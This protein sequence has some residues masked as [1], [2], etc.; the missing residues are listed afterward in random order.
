MSNSATET[1]QFCWNELMTK[2]TEKA[3]SFYQALLGWEA[4]EMKVGELVYTVFKAGGKEMG[5]MLQIPAAEEQNIPPHWM[6]YIA[7]ADLDQAVKKAEQLGARVK[8]PQT[9]LGNFGRFATIIDPSG[10]H[11][12]FWQSL[13]TCED[14]NDSYHS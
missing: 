14:I 7:V 13:K 1:N 9:M 2:D 3:K 12:A 4:T 11:I 8:C 10:A 5:G 6:S